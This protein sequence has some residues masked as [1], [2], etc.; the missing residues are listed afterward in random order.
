MALSL[1]C[2][3]ASPG[4]LLAAT[5]L[6]VYKSPFTG[7]SAYYET[8]ASKALEGAIVATGFEVALRKAAK[9]DE[10]FTNQMA[11]KRIKNTPVGLF[12]SG[13]EIGGR[14]TVTL[15]MV[16]VET[17]AILCQETHGATA[18]TLDD[19]DGAFSATLA[20]GMAKYQELKGPGVGGAPKKRMTVAV[21]DFE[22]V[23]TSKIE[24]V[25]VGD[26]MREALVKQGRFTVL[27]R[28]NMTAI[29]KEQSFQQSGCTT[30]E[31]RV[32][33]GQL[34][35]AELVMSGQLVKVGDRWQVTAKSLDVATAKFVN[36]ARVDLPDLNKAGPAIELLAESLAETPAERLAKKE[37]Q[38]KIARRNLV[39]SSIGTGVLG[40]TGLGFQLASDDSL[41]SLATI[42][43]DYQNQTVTSLA[44]PLGD[45]LDKTRQDTDTLLTLRDT[46]FIA[47]GALLVTDVLLALKVISIEKSIKGEKSLQIGFVPTPNGF[48]ISASM[49]F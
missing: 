21:I 22:P 42:Y 11:Q 14:L 1:F 46:A 8:R 39:L 9:S 30:E 48:R 45:R 29:L 41:R 49:Q 15:R 37:A 4:I 2:S 7:G 25:M 17:S 36:V 28:K 19:L 27:D 18:E 6:V 5:P 38:L 34:L 40:L 24:A 12:Y 44:T 47:A 26:L 31:C 33:L 35:N 13:S 10:D 20:K 3:L 43:T 23:G 16:D 32:Q